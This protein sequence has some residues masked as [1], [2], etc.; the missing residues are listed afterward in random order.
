MDWNAIGAIGEILGAIGVIVSLIYLGTQIRQNSQ[1]LKASIV[2]SA[3]DRLGDIVST[4][5]SNEDLSRIIRIGMHG[6]TSE[7]NI[8]E[9]HRLALVMVRSF[10]GHE[11]S[12]A[13]NLSGL[14]DDQTYRGQIE[15]MKLWMNSDIFDEWWR[16]TS[17]IFNSS[18][19]AKVEEVR[20]EVPATSLTMF[21]ENSVS[22][23][24][25]E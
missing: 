10:R 3:G 20:L 24:E 18:F 12:F 1:W 7:L 21:Q 22:G 23:Q 15:N 9:R 14:L 25:S 4:V 17:P 11:V 16:N 13:H 8:D 6:D 19:R 2:E 5:M